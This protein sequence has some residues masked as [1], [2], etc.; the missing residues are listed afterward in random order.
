MNQSQDLISLESQIR[1]DQENVSPSYCVEFLKKHNEDIGKFGLFLFSFEY[2]S[3]QVTMKKEEIIKAIIPSFPSHLD[4]FL[5]SI[6]NISNDV[7]K[8]NRYTTASYMSII[9]DSILKVAKLSYEQ[10]AEILGKIIQPPYSLFAK[11]FIKGDMKLREHLEKINPEIYRELDNQI[12]NLYKLLNCFK[13]QYYYPEVIHCDTSNPRISKFGGS[14][15]YLPSRGPKVCS[16]GEAKLQPVFS[17]YVPSL[18]QKIKD[19]FPSNHEYVVVGYSCESCYEELEVE[20]FTDAEI[21]ELVYDGV[22]S[23]DYVFNEA[24]TVINWRQNEMYPVDLKNSGFDLPNKEKYSDE[25]IFLIEEILDYERQNRE[26]T[27]L[28]GYPVFIQED[29]TP[30]DHQLLIE[31]EESEASTNIWGDCGTC[32]VWMK[33]GDDFGS[34]IMSY[35]CS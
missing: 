5:A 32:Q 10:L 20:L 34:F 18:P 24:R 15:P 31:M 26:P 35:D 1:N 22:A 17:L 33:T 29:N 6:F 11:V 21:D 2:E 9:K 7:I 8:D 14:C 19:L 16:C 30:P 27:Y 28:G 13:K 25:E 23:D 4:I 3:Y 12:N